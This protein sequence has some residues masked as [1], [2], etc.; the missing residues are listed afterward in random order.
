MKRLKIGDQ[1]AEIKDY[2]CDDGNGYIPKEDGNLWLY[3]NIADVC[4]AHCP[5]CINPCRSEGNTSF[6]I[7]SFRDTLVQIRDQISGVSITGG[8]PML[9]PKL[10]DDVIGTV[11]NVFGRYIETDI[12]TNG[13]NFRQ[14]RDLKHMDLLDSVHLSRHMIN[15]AENNKVFGIPV[16]SAEEIRDV[17]MNLSDP[18]RVTFNCILMKNGINS[19]ERIAEYLEFAA[20]V[21]VSNTS[22][23]GMAPA[24]SFCIANYVDPSGFDFSTDPRF[25]IWNRLK[26][27]DFCRCSSGS[28]RAENRSVRFYYRCIGSQRAEYAR[29]LVYTADNRLLAGF[30]GKEI[31]LDQNEAV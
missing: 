29:Q 31:H 6:D 7:H 14:I 25:E 12:V 26:D 18:A 30:N 16:A 8:E 5:F 20:A 11:N 23:I 3:V 15:D 4:N 21:N 24:N 1:I 17:V 28:Y 10:V 13:F 9:F 2:Y 22:F 27:H 19:V